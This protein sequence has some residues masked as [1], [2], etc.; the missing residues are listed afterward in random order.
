[1][2]DAKRI[3]WLTVE[4]MLGRSFSTPATGTASAATYLRGDNTWAAA[5]AGSVASTDI[6]D[7]STHG[8]ELL[9]SSTPAAARA[10]IGAGT[11][12][13]PG[14]YSSLS[15]IP[16]SFTPAAHTHPVSELSD[17]TVNMELAPAASQ[18]VA[19]GYGR[20][21]PDYY[22]VPNGN[23]LDLAAGAVVEVG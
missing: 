3:A 1:M 2:S 22:E 7:A 16:S 8:K 5:S 4:E 11:S 23:Y 14:D 12:S 19:A 15:G 9:T 20:Y 18:T 21:V 6:S 13:F 17:F 10:A